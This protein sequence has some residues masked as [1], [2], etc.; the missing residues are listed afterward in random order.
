MYAFIWNEH[1]P[2]SLSLPRLI[3][4]HD[5]IT[6]SASYSFGNAR[7]VNYTRLPRSTI[8][9]IQMANNYKMC[10]VASDLDCVPKDLEPPETRAEKEQKPG[11]PTSERVCGEKHMLLPWYIIE[12]KKARATNRG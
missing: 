8:T 1:F 7:P 5:F 4:K 3:P 11:E 12:R 6:P 2:S 10:A 9:K